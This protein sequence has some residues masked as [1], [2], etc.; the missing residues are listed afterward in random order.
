MKHKLCDIQLRLWVHLYQ[1]EIMNGV[2]YNKYDELIQKVQHACMTYSALTSPIWRH[3]VNI[4]LTYFKA[5][6]C[7]ALAE[8][9]LHGWHEEIRIQFFIVLQQA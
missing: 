5:S 3:S 8:Y 6:T 1:C 9:S 2:N 7:S 4:L